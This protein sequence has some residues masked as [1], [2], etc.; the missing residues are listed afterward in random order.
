MVWRR[1][2]GLEI[3]ACGAREAWRQKGFKDFKKRG[4]SQSF[5]MLRCL[6]V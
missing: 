4:C 3:E 5:Q 2:V 1:A 6:V